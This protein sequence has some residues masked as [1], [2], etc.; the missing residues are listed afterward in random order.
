MLG[1]SLEGLSSKIRRK[2]GKTKNIVIVDDGSFTGNQM[3]NNISGASRIL[4]TVYGHKK[5]EFH[6]IV[7]FVTKPAAK[8][9]FSLKQKVHL[10][11]SPMAM[12]S[13]AE[14][15]PAKYLDRG[16][17]L[18][19]LHKSRA[20]SAALTYFSHKIPNSMS[21]PKALADG[22]FIPDFPP[23]YKR[24]QEQIEESKAG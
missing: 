1:Y 14:V 20:S 13:V 11:T 10:Y 3:A 23:P 15:I 4:E 6:V 21:F 9:L 19:G 7:P 12:K 24:V 17:K 2:V 22:G 5:H 8:K 18:L 16:L